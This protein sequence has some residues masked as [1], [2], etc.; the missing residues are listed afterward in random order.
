M[1]LEEEGDIFTV[2]VCKTTGIVK[3][4]VKKEQFTLDIRT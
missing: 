3:E 4:I 2:K 1:R